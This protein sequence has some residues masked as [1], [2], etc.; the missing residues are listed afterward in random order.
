MKAQVE[1][2]APH[3]HLWKLIHDMRFGMLTTRHADGV[4]HSRPLTTQN[5]K[6]DE[7]ASLWF[8][9]AL[10]GEPARDVKA[11]PMVNV[12]YASPEKDCY[13]SVSGQAR[14]V[15]DAER[16]KALWSAS[17]K[18]WFVGGLEDPDLGLLEVRIDRAEF[19]DVKTSK[20]VQL[21]KMAKAAV[22]GVPPSG[23]GEHGEVKMR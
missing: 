20:M 8:F 9:V 14:I 13:V 18:A 12:S 5:R 23:M 19:W 2:E 22:S 15:D 6:L 17:A 11:D 4:L 3:E 21:Y 7:G 16:K 1:S 10:S